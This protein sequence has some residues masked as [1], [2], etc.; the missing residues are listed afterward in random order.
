MRKL[1]RYAKRRIND[2]KK[3][4]SDPA[5]VF[6]RAKDKGELDQTDLLEVL[7]AIESFRVRVNSISTTN[8][9]IDDASFQALEELAGGTKY[10]LIRVA[11][12]AVYFNRVEK[13][14]D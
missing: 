5:S 13:S 12:N 11:A 7:E 8:F 3:P 9:D 1:F 4:P 10:D 14:D 2:V 6:R